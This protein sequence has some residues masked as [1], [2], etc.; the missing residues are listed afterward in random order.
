MDY[1]KIEEHAVAAVRKAIDEVRE[2]EPAFGDVV[3]QALEEAGAP[4]TVAASLG[5][6]IEAI[7]AHFKSHSEAAMT[8]VP[9]APIA[10]T[11]FPPDA[12]ARLPQPSEVAADGRKMPTPAV[13]AQ[14][15]P[16]WNPPSAT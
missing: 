16:V 15:I 6:L 11:E 14:A 10:P 2:H 3:V 12:A 1:S 13:P 5:D 8:A 7:L 4:A 9:A